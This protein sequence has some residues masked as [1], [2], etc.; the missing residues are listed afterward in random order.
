MKTQ[1]K[2]DATKAKPMTT[3]ELIRIMT[4]TGHT[5]QTLA[6]KIGVSVRTVQRYVAGRSIPFH[7]AFLIRQLVR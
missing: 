7:N 5:P 6:P 3:A 1:R 4:R 2:P